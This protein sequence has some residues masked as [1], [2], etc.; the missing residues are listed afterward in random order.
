MDQNTSKIDWDQVWISIP[1]LGCVLMVLALLY[2]A[3]VVKP[4]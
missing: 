1:L 2:D 3:F 4:W